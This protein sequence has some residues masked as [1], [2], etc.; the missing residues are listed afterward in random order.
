MTDIAEILSQ[1]ESAPRQDVCDQHG[2]FES[3]N[4]FGR[5]WSP[6][7]ICAAEK[8]Q[9]DRI[10]AVERKKADD[11]ARWNGTLRWAGIPDRFMDRTLKSYRAETEGQRRALAFAEAYA[12]DF[13]V[14]MKTGRSAV[15]V[16][17]PGTGKTHLA[18]GIGLRIMHRDGRTVLF[19]TVMR[20][21]RRIRNTWGRNGEESETEAIAALTR[22][23]L[24]IL[25]EVGI[26]CGTENEKL[27]IFDLLN[28]RY[29]NRWPTLLLSNLP[30][31]E[32]KQYLGERVYDRLREDG[33]DVVTF[34][35][36]SHRGRGEV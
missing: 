30:L 35:W 13:D 31:D 21:I 1:R 14:A 24:L 32:V 5:L 27:L 17:K 2:N 28:E 20:A 18:V 34:D 29:E 12:E 10:A 36:D 3:R 7:P 19:S 16:G 6:C 22:P 26:Q 9:A 33:G 25:D 8:D 4:V 23:D 11:L 15:F